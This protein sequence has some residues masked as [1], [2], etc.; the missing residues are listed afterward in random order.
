MRTQLRM[1]KEGPQV[2][3]HPDRLKAIFKK[4][5]NWKTPNLDGVHGFSL[6]NSPSYTINLLRKSINTYRKLRYPNER[7][8]KSKK[9]ALSEEPPQTNHN[10]PTD[11]VENTDG[12]NF[13]DQLLINKRQNLPRGADRMLQ[14]NQRLRGNT[15]YKSTHCQ[16]KLK[17]DW[18][19]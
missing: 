10:A 7:P 17:K 19:I 12:T 16:R 3:I 8:L 15:I 1:L 4:V 11:D 18:K 13:G 2:N 6:R 14:E 9:K 5:S